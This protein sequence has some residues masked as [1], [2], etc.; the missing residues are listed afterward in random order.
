MQEVCLH[1]ALPQA[2]RPP[3]P[4]PSRARRGQYGAIVE[5]TVHDRL[6]DA[7]DR[8]QADPDQWP[9][10]MQFRQRASCSCASTMPRW[11][12]DTYRYVE[13]VPSV[14][15]FFC[16]AHLSRVLGSRLL[17]ILVC[18]FVAILRCFILL[19]FFSNPVEQTMGQV[20]VVMVLL[21]RLHN[22]GPF[23]R[24]YCS[25]RFL[26]QS[27]SNLRSSSS[28]WCS[29]FISHTLSKGFNVLWLSSCYN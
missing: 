25:S 21:C 5:L 6:C 24:F 19:H 18:S 1:H 28:L 22:F 15:E 11:M 16:S 23:L 17:E 7:C 14:P 20:G 29:V 9:A 26:Q 8:S 2:L 12:F 27:E 4:H 13:R 3:P 10:V